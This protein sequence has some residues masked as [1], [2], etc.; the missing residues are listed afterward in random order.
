MKRISGGN[1]K[2]DELFHVFI[3]LDKYGQDK[4]LDILRSLVVIQD[5]LTNPQGT[6][7]CKR[8]LSNKEKRRV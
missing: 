3:T 4:A 1:R 6:I 8:Q 5:T 2:V 7:G